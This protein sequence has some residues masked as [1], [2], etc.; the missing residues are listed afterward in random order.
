M[1]SSNCPT[2]NRNAPFPSGKEA[3]LSYAML[4]YKANARIYQKILL[5]ATG[6]L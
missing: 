3:L 6:V 4:F 5:I 1:L 2:Q